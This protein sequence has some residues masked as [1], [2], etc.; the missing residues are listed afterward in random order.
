LRISR[1]SLASRPDLLICSSKW[2]DVHLLQ[3][4]DNVGAD[5]AGLV[6]MLPR[7]V[8]AQRVGNDN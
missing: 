4:R 2:A 1:E 3:V 5:L 7:S 6:A 8:M